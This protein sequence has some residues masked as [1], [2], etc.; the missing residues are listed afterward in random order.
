MTAM[1]VMKR[2]FARLVV[3]LP[4]AAYAGEQGHYVPGSWS[5][6]DLIS[7]PAG[8]T[9]FAPYVSFRDADKARTGRGATVDEGEGVAVGADSWMLPPVL[10][11]APSVKPLGAD[12]AIPVVP[13][14]G[15]AGANARGGPL[16]GS[17][18]CKQ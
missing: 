8:L 4:L 3:L 5:P 10:V 7:A 13:A 17:E 6:G 15:E 1:I 11:Y 9:G 14:Y 2:T 18:D 16:S 12:W